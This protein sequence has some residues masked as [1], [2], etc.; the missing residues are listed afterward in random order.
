M[1]SHLSVKSLMHPHLLNNHQNQLLMTCLTFELMA[2]NM[3]SVRI[4][5]GEQ[6]LFT[7][8][9]RVCWI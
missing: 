8:Y 2:K 1:K 9:S 6:I 4:R 3:K 5:R 7:L